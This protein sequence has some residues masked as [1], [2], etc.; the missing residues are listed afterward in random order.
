[1]AYKSCRVAILHL[2]STPDHSKE[3]VKLRLD[4]IDEKLA[5]IDKLRKKEGDASRMLDMNSS[6]SWT[7]LI[8]SQAKAQHKR[9]SCLALIQG[10]IGRTTIRRSWTKRLIS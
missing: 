6:W 7:Y 2:E 9:P 1:M 8:Q 3:T 10:S 4:T 5:D